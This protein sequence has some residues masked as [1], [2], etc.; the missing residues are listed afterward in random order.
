MK[1]SESSL[2]NNV[3]LIIE[4]ARQLVEKNIDRTMSLSYFLIGKLIIEEEQH[5]N[6]RAKYADETI[7]AFLVALCVSL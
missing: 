6:E 7:Y 5:G 3:R 1:K 4:S 2:P